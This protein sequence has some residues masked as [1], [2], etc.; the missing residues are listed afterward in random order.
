MPAENKDMEKILSQIRARLI[1][2]L[3]LKPLEVSDPNVQLYRDLNLYGDD[4]VEFLEWYFEE[5]KLSTENFS[6]GDYF[7]SEGNNPIR[8]ISNLWRRKKDYENYLPISL[9]SL[10]RLAELGV[11]QDL[12]HED[13]VGGDERQA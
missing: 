8:L 4:A 9:V 13:R 11:W 10:A 5:F 1:T 7:P 3:S 6:F 12:E 2:T